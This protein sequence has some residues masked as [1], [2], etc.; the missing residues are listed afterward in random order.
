MILSCGTQGG[1]KGTAYNPVAASGAGRL[2][3][4]NPV[5]W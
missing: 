1:Y 4:Y 3:A 2:Q 5:L